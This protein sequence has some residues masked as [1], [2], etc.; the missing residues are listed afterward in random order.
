MENGKPDLGKKKTIIPSIQNTRGRDKNNVHENP[1]GKKYKEL[2]DQFETE[3][4][5]II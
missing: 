3:S 2:G 4:E 5:K 1:I